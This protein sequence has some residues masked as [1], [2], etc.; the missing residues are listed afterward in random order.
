MSWLFPNFLYTVHIS[1]WNYIKSSKLKFSIKVSHRLNWA[2]SITLFAFN[3]CRRRT[4]HPKLK[5]PLK[6]L[7]LTTCCL[8]IQR[9]RI[10]FSTDPDALSW[11]SVVIYRSV[12]MSLV[13]RTVQVINKRLT[14]HECLSCSLS[15][16]FYSAMT[17]NLPQSHTIGLIESMN[18]T[19]FYNFIP[20]TRVR[21]WSRFD[22]I[23]TTTTISLS[24]Q[25]QVLNFVEH[26]SL[27]D[28]VKNV[29]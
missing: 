5:L 1:K 15:S 3:L 18:L 8:F 20:E 27:Y 23:P 13:C 10:F 21:S 12:L 9:E 6:H 17:V 14:V 4:S 19:A 29:Y 24:C 25:Q 11:R 28:C 26:S 2:P 7:S 16:A 22:I